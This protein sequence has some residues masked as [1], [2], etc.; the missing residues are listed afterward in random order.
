MQGASRSYDREALR[1]EKAAE[2]RNA[3]RWRVGLQG[4]TQ[5]GRYVIAVL[6][7]LSYLLHLAGAL[8]TG[9]A[10][11]LLPGI[12]GR[13]VGTAGRQRERALAPRP[14]VGGGRQRW[15]Q[16][17]VSHALVV[18]W[19]A[20]PKNRQHR[21]RAGLAYGGRRPAAPGVLCLGSVSA[22]HPL[23]PPQVR[24]QQ[25]IPTIWQLGSCFGCTPSLDPS[26]C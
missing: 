10:R 24:V 3:S 16:L 22:L 6:T 25:L 26:G 13:G 20:H 21:V 4:G 19:V 2:G 15:R 14:G 23:L 8:R 12:R 5:E 18:L 11:R 1:V 7:S 17:L 9:E